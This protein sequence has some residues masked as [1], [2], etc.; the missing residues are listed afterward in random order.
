MTCNETTECALRHKRQDDTEKMIAQMYEIIC[1]GIHPENSLSTK[2]D[3]MYTENRAIKNFIKG[4]LISLVALIFWCGY[5]FAILQGCVDKIEKI[6]V[7]LESIR[8]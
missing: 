4:C 6:E 8:G 3:E 1:G 2:V 7:Q 5:Q